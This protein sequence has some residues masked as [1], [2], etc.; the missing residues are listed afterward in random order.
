VVRDGED[1]QF[2]GNIIGLSYPFGGAFTPFV[3]S[4]GLVN[5]RHTKILNNNFL[6]TGSS[7]TI[8]G[9]STTTG[10]LVRDNFH[11]GFPLVVLLQGS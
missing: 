11:N 1:N 6:N 4:F 3:H 7:A 9:T 2:I 8:Y 10:T 5:A